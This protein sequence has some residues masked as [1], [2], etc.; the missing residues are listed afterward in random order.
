MSTRKNPKLI[1][2]VFV[3]CAS[4]NECTGLLQKITLDPAEVRKF[5]RMFNS[6]DSFEDNED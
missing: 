5:H 3:D 1:D 4:A 6:V 2:E